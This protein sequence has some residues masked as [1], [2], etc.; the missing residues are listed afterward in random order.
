MRWAKPETAEIARFTNS[1]HGVM[2]ARARDIKTLFD[3]STADAEITMR[4]IHRDG[5]EQE[6]RMRGRDRERPKS[7][8]AE[9]VG[10]AARDKAQV[11]NRGDAIAQ[12]IGGPVLTLRS[13]GGI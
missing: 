11:G 9:D 13:E 7:N 1:R 2:A 6:R 5:T 3:Q 10:V 8:R 12:A 4:C